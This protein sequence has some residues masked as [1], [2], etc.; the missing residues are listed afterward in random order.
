MSQ[1]TAPVEIDRGA[2]PEQDAVAVEAPLQIEIEGQPVATLMRTPG[3]DL[4]LVTG[5]LWT[6]GLIEDPDDVQAIAHC[7]DPRKPHRENIVRVRLAAGAPAIGP[8]L[9]SMRR[10]LYAHG[11]CGVC[12]KAS[13]DQIFLQAPR[14]PASDPPERGQVSQWPRLLRAHQPIF[15]QTGGLHGAALISRDY[16]VTAAEDIGRHNAVDKVIG[17]QIR[18]TGAPPEGLALMVSSRVGFEI[19]Q[20]ALMARLWALAAVGAASSLADEAA[21]AGGLH[22]FTW[23]RGDRAVYHG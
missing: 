12:G 16:V 14:R 19:V 7:A 15:E 17:A 11:G 21:R 13:I 22:L 4:E 1:P 5:F 23:V 9:E 20:K 10:A 8:R 3:A 18:A 6:E 2:G